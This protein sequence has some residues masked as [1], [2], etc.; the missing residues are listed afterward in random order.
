[1]EQTEPSDGAEE[2]EGE[3]EDE[4]RGEEGD[5]ESKSSTLEYD[6]GAIAVAAGTLIFMLSRFDS[7]HA[8][9][10]LSLLTRRSQ[11]RWTQAISSLEDEE[12]GQRQPRRSSQQNGE[13]CWTAS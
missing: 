12:R 6:E 3:A 8:K 11:T 10:Y 1:M 4:E 5:G 2:D 7:L 9:T 13:A